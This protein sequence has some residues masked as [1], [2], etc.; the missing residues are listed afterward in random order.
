[1]RKIR[2]IVVHCTATD[3]PQQWNM[4]ALK[5]LHTASKDIR[6]K[7]GEYD[8]TGKGWNDVGYHASIARDGQIELG[9]P[10]ATV[11]AGVYGHNADS[12]HVALHGLDN[13]E[14][15]QFTGLFTLFESWEIICN[16]TLADDED[17]VE[18][19][20]HYELDPNK[21]CPNTDMDILRMNYRRYKINKKANQRLKES[22]DNLPKRVE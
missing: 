11:G 18:I 21:P 15:E 19:V 14:D 20:G 9:R 4:T 10:L 17:T 5:Y 3:N 13:F 7:W 1:M 12:A 16:E 6:I 2:K 8:T 22:T